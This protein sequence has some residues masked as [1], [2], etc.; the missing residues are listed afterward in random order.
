MFLDQKEKKVFEFLK[1][2]GKNT[3]VKTLISQEAMNRKNISKEITT[4]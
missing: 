1:K 2:T 4:W 3:R